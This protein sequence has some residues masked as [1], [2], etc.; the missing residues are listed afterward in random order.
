MSKNEWLPNNEEDEE[1]DGDTWLPRIKNPPPTEPPAD[2][3]MVSEVR[4]R[5]GQAPTK[6]PTPRPVPEI[7]APPVGD[8]LSAAREEYKAE[9]ERLSL[10]EAIKQI[11]DSVVQYAAA[12]EGKRT[13]VDMSGLQLPQYD[14][15][16]EKDRALQDY[17]ARVADEQQRRD[18]QRAID[19]Q[20]LRRDELAE[21]R[22]FR[23]RQEERAIANQDLQML[24][25][26]GEQSMR[27]A[28]FTAG[29]QDKAFQREYMLA[30]LELA[31]KNTENQ[32]ALTSAKLRGKDPNLADRFDKR[33]QQLQKLS[34]EMSAKITDILD[35]D[36]YNDDRKRAEIISVFQANNYPL[37]QE[38]V[39]EL[40]MRPR[41]L[42]GFELWKSSLKPAEAREAISNYL[43]QQVFGEATAQPQ[44]PNE[45][46]VYRH[47]ET[48]QLTTP[49]TRR[50]NEEYPGGYEL[51]EDE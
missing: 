15:G 29:E 10:L 30:Q 4:R 24:Q 9:K 38:K 13:G 7:T 28:M 41:T 37:S 39:E 21:E 45:P 3:A 16:R 8:E 19:E 33:Y 1:L 11:A 23:Q 6:P 31:R 22:M 20:K 36:E 42:F 49:T 48:G 12:S 46:R 47:V 25:L 51:V 32:A 17:R 18:A 40:T 27:K 2:D 5:L 26:L 44:T 14:F 35:N 34:R 50:L 43:I